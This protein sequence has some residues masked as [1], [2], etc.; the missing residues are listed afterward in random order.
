MSF[1]AS[2]KVLKVFG[3]IDIVLGIFCIITGAL[4]LGGGGLAASTAEYADQAG[5][6][7]V[8]GVVV[9]L[10]GIVGLIEGILC[11]RAAKDPSK[12]NP[13]WVIAIIGLVM[14]V[15]SL[16]LDIKN[17]SN[18]G[19]GIVSLLVNALIFVSA[20]TIKKENG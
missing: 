12:I 16:V 20:N 11:T 18:I 10:A 2:R 4:A 13:A 6:I 3:I 14:A 7:I 1:D 9:L 5:V 19:S 17:G 15:I 8:A